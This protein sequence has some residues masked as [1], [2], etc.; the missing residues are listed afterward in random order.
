LSVFNSHILLWRKLIKSKNCFLAKIDRSY[1]A[2]FDSPQTL[3]AIHLSTLSPRGLQLA[4]EKFCNA[5]EFYIS[6]I[7]KLASERMVSIRYEDLCKTPAD[8]LRRII[9]K[10]ALPVSEENLHARPAPRK[11]E[12]LPEVERV[13]R[14]NANRIEPYLSHMGFG[15]MPHD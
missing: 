1:D 12:I 15:L 11:I 9:D 6:H 14:A 13:Y 8:V 4:F 2:V 7:H 5:Y 3:Q 10:L